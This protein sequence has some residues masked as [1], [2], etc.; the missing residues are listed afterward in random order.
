MGLIEECTK[1][2]DEKA[3]IEAKLEEAVRNVIYSTTY[4]LMG[5]EDMKNNRR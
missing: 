3:E 4:E 1:Y 2:E 5:G